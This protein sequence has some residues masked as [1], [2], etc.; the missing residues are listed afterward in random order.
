MR[1][2]EDNVR[3]ICDETK[4]DQRDFLDRHANYVRK[5]MRMDYDWWTCNEGAEGV[6]KSTGGIHQARRVGR[7][8]FDLD[9][10]IVWDPEDFLRLVDDTPRYGVIVLDE[11]G[12]AI[13]S[14]DFNTEMNKA[15][16]KTSQQMRD[17]NL[18]VVYNLP[19]LELLD[20]AL[21]RRFKTLVIYEAPNFERGRSLWHVPVHPRYGKKSEPFWDFQ[22]VYYFLQLPP[23]IKEEYVRRKSQY[24]R[25]RV[26]KYLEEVTRMND[27]SQ[28]VD[29]HK[30]AEQISKLKP[31]DKQELLSNRGSWS[32][33][34]IR[35]KFRCSESVARAVVAGLGAPPAAPKVEA[36]ASV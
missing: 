30:L 22:W 11:A 27:S 3:R 35:F 2:P 29:P 10:H 36:G 28:D 1:I 18:Y 13:F 24:G 15:I 25:E 33:D 20:T 21:R 16:V 6:G 31:N 32:R 19:T 9:K 26:A 5:I 7:D 34:K 17:R 14:R 8:L 23:R 4:Q 12:E